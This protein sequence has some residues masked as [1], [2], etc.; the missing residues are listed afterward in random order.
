MRFLVFAPARREAVLSSE[1]VAVGA[2][3]APDHEVTLVATDIEDGARL[4]HSDGVEVIDHGD[5]ARVLAAAGFAD[6]VLYQVGNSYADFGGALTWIPRVT[7][8]IAVHDPFLG[9]LLAGL[10]R[11]DPRTAAW[12]VG[13]NAPGRYGRAMPW[14]GT[15]R[16][17]LL[18][19]GQRDLWNDWL[20]N[21]AALVLAHSSSAQDVLRMRLRRRVELLPPLW[22]AP[23][24]QEPEA[25]GPQEGTLRIVSIAGA[26]D[27][28]SLAEI[29][30]AIANG[31][32]RD[33]VEWRV[34]GLADPV[35]RQHL[36][37]LAEDLGIALLFLEPGAVSAAAFA[38]AR[39]VT[40]VSDATLRG[41]VGWVLA[42]ARQAPT[43]V[44]AGGPFT[45]VPDVLVTARHDDL[46]DWVSR[47]LN[48]PLDT[49]ATSR[50]VRP[51]PGSAAAYAEALVALARRSERAG[52]RRLALHFPDV[53]TWDALDLE[54]PAT[55]FA[56]DMAIF[57]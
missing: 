29:G 50:G 52:R 53:S 23:P 6:L 16:R 31:A 57:S 54:T 15:E 11:A 3:L 34:A 22:S 37:H 18:V 19:D 24:A 55:V 21:D 45:D 2:A 26:A 12:L 47:A 17:S 51:F 42:A 27:V 28:G 1:M 14:Y 30:Y 8:H 5:D 7:G 56:A 33:A 9:D 10:G 39:L 32:R 43:L 4:A 44:R 25:R 48:G 13:R 49:P 36:A 38:G 40:A 41:A 35:Q 46:V 20:L